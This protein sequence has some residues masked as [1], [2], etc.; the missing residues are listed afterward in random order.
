MVYRQVGGEIDRI[1]RTALDS[2]V[3]SN[4]V[5]PYSRIVRA[6][7]YEWLYRYIYRKLWHVMVEALPEVFGDNEHNINFD[8][9]IRFARRFYYIARY[10]L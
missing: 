2:Y 8:R 7:N 3:M 10:V 1:V 6:V 4:M 9:L 5:M